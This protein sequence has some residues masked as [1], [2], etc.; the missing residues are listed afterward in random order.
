MRSF[1][2]PLAALSFACT[3]SELAPPAQ[4]PPPE[5]AA[6]MPATRP[7][8]PVP[9][10]RA[11]VPI[12][13][14]RSG[15]DYAPADGQTCDG[16][17]PC[18]C[19]AQELFHGVNA[20]ARIGVEA[21]AL[22]AGT[23]CLLADFDGNGHTDALFLAPPGPSGLSLAVALLFDEVGLSATA[24]VPKPVATLGLA[25]GVPGR[26]VLAGPDGVRF[27]FLD[28][29]FRAALPAPRAPPSSVD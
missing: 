8:V 7:A 3:Q 19:R 25:E 23:P 6:S 18:P 20:L 15:I 21:S 14:N 17:A 27:V 22:E 11:P 4:D 1:A 28:G 10:A 26:A 5:S 29:R 9:A 24:D 12:G 2:F 16:E 13:E